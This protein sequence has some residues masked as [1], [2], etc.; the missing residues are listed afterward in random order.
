MTPYRLTWDIIAASLVFWVLITLWETG[1]LS[2]EGLKV[3]FFRALIF[4]MIYAAI[5]VALVV[6]KGKDK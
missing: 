3:N 2:T 5:R 1:G 4:A 6:F